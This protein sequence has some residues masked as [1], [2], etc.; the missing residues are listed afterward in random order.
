MVAAVD[1]PER[2][3]L[4]VC[5]FLVAA[6]AVLASNLSGQYKVVCAAVVAYSLVMTAFPMYAGLVD[7]YN[8]YCG[9]Q[10]NEAHITACKEQGI[11]D[12]TIPFIG[13]DTKYSGFYKMQYLTSDPDYWPN[14]QMA[15]YYGLNSIRTP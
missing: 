12:V 2:S 13:A 8:G 15:D 3:T 9:Q 4:P 6:T 14:W 10:D 7:I 11:L 1:Y 5:V